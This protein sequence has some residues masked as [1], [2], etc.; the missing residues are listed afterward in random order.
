MN[1]DMAVLHATVQDHKRAPVSGLKKDDFQVFED[2]F[3]QQIKYF[4]HEDIPVTVGLAVD[5]SGSM[6]SKDPEVIAAALAFARSSSPQDQMFVINFNEHVWFTLPGNMPFTDQR[7]Q[8]KAAL[9]RITADGMTA[10]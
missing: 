5:N 4:S 6:R 7:T 10:L 3:L 2:G 8:L 9:S 1:V